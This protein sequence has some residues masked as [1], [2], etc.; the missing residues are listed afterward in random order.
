MHFLSKWRKHP[1]TS[2]RVSIQK[3]AGNRKQSSLGYI[4]CFYS[5]EGKANH[6]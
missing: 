2:A 1:F 6:V 3:Q 5:N 4:E